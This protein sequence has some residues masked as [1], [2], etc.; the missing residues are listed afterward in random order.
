MLDQAIKALAP[1]WA[2]RRAQARAATTYYEQAGELAAS[3]AYWRGSS[4]GRVDTSWA[5]DDFVARSTRG[6]REK[7]GLG[8]MRERA[9]NLERNN[10]LASALLGASVNFVVGSGSRIEPQTGNDDR[11]REILRRWDDWWNATP[12]MTGLMTGP[13]LER[14]LY[15][16]RQRDGDVAI[17]LPPTGDR[18]QVIEAKQIH[19]P[20]A[21]LVDANIVDG[22]QVNRVGEPVRFWI[23]G[24]S[25]DGRNTQ[26]TG[27]P[28]SQVAYLPRLKRFNQVRGETVFSA[29][30]TLLDQFDGLLEGTVI[31][32]RIATLFALLIKQ[33]RNPMAGLPDMSGP[34]DSG[35]T[36]KDFKLEPGLIK[37]IGPADEITQ[38]KPEH[39]NQQLDPL[40]TM[41]SRF[42]ALELYLPLEVA[43]L[44]FRQ[45][46]YS[47]ARAAIITSQRGA[48][49][50]HKTFA[51]RGLSRIYRWW[52]ARQVREGR[53][54]QDGEGIARHK[55]IRDP[56]QYL[57]PVKEVEGA[58]L[59]IDGGL[60]TQSEALMGRGSSFGDW[61]S[62]RSEEVGKLR[63]GG[64][65]VGRSA[66][67]RDSGGHP[68]QNNAQ[69]DQG[70][71]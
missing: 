14:N 13:D 1:A 59:A 58:L 34:A 4:A 39:P 71:E 51:G 10:F 11:D 44:D 35:Q 54:A 55:V 31:A 20:P 64:V 49:A 38:V 36:W 48:T 43:L 17:Y 27:L 45:T 28:A 68:Q 42:A 60:M 63:E 37:H 30:F 2:A 15:R 19:S 62:R 46:N 7:I 18:V 33:S 3:A 47:S 12:E 29:Q 69:E 53:I 52:L 25:A 9:G 6:M 24:D 16:A 57:D 22:V 32:A 5:N 66:K 67:T 41:L 23:E 8:R 56:Q 65:V 50:D 40:I 61:L 21:G 70:D 26:Y